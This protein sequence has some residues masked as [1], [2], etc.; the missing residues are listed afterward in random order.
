MRLYVA[1]AMVT[2]FFLVACPPPEPPLNET[3]STN[4][5]VEENKT[6]NREDP[7]GP[8]AA[9]CDNLLSVE[10]VVEFC[11]TENITTNTVRKIQSCRK[12][13][14]SG[15]HYLNIR[16]VAF[17]N[18]NDALGRYNGDLKS[19][20]GIKFFAPNKTSFVAIENLPHIDGRTYHGVILAK[21]DLSSPKFCDPAKVV[22]LLDLVRE[23]L[24]EEPFVPKEKE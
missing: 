21:A 7:F 15:I 4:S 23:R 5:T 8:D 17:D 6:M 10:E 3:N 9:F 22:D 18:E 19:F 24:I 13:F 2:L 1:L 14:G 11:G 16:A 20:E 12:H